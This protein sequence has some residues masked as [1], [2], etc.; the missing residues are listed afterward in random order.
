MEDMLGEIKQNVD[1]EEKETLISIE[2][3]GSQSQ[4]WVGRLTRKTQSR[5]TAICFQRVR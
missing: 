5:P 2:D 4:G 1:G 3:S